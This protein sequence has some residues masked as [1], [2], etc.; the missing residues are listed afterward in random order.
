MKVGGTRRLVIPADMA[1][2][3]TP[4]SGSGIPS[5]ADLVFDVELISVQ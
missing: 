4:P 5:N 2:G 1:Y 3:A